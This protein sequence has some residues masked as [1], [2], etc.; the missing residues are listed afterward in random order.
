MSRKREIT[1]MGLGVLT[2][3]ALLPAAKAGVTT[4]TATLSTQ[5]IYVDGQRIPMTAYAIGGNNYVKL[6][7][8]G[9]AVGFGVTYDAAT[10][11]VY[12]DSNAPYQEA[13]SQPVQVAASPSPAA[14]TE[15]SVKATLAELKVRYPAMSTYP[16]PYTSTSNPPYGPTNKN[17]AGWAILCSDAA[18][19]NLPWRKVDRPGWEQIRP[20]DLV[21]MRGGGLNHGVIVL[22]RTED[23]I[24][25]TE[26]GTNQNVYWGAQYFRWWLED[27]PTYVL[28]TRYPT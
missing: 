18:F 28:Y 22:E 20:G 2:G 10:N 15:E 3:L 8:I 26:S 24:L 7:D 11:S 14:V 27:Q 21:E 13:V 12:I 17:C 9:K 16:S 25:T 19:G 4:L 5:P 1:M 23:Y 6:R